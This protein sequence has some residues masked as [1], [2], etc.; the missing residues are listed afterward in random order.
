MNK[1]QEKKKQKEKI[2]KIA[3]DGRTYG[4]TEG[5]TDGHDLL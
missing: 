2:A 4:R 3:R 5:T 1:E